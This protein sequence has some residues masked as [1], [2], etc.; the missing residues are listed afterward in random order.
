[1]FFFGI[2]PDAAKDDDDKSLGLREES[3]ATIS[4]YRAK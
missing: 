3:L 4:T 1:M 2:V